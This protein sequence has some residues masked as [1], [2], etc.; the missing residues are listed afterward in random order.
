MPEVISDCIAGASSAGTS[1]GRRPPGPGAGP[2]RTARRAD[3]R[4]RRSGRARGRRHRRP[5][6][7]GLLEAPTASIKLRHVNRPNPA[8]V[9]ETLPCGRS[10]AIGRIVHLRCVRGRRPPRL[11][12]R[13]A[14]P[15]VG[16]GRR[17]GDG[18][19]HRP[20]AHGGPAR[21]PLA[22]PRPRPV[23]PEGAPDLVL[24]VR[25][26]VAGTLVVEVD[27]Q[28]APGGWD[29][30]ESELALFAAERL[31]G[32]VAVH[33]AVIAARRARPARARLLRARA[34]AACAWRRRPPGAQ[35]L[36]DEYA[37][38]DLA[39]GAVTGWPRAVRVRRADGAVDRVDLVE[40]SAPLPVG[41]VALVRFEP[42]AT[43][44]LAPHLAGR[45]R[46]G[47]ARQHRLRADAGPTTPSTPRCSSAAPPTRWA[48]SAAR[49]PPPSTTSC[50][51]S[52]ST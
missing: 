26:A 18:R 17:R 45:R 11:G 36:S 6:A 3:G 8:L 5:R 4:A 47:S 39:S 31:T 33:A 19:R 28:P 10:S 52:P 16:T 48:G 49:R 29:R 40:P 20:G 2:R 14:P 50:G 34:R 9:R 22:A 21:R 51:P 15:A 38:V 46:H 13:A 23:D 32:R 24:E 1:A 25:S 37:L 35:V 27:G 43:L 12:P 41:L 7:E 30:I 44:T 42:G